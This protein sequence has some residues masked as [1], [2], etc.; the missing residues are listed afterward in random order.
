MAYEA[1]FYPGSSVIAEN[2]KK[3]MNPDYE[4]KTMRNIA[5][6][7][8]V[9]LLSHRTPG[10]GYKTV[11][12]PLDEMDFEEDAVKD[13]VEPL[14]GAKK[15]IRIRYV[16]FADSMYNAPAHPYDRARTY[17][18]RYRGVDTGTLSGRQV[19]EMR[20]SDLEEMSKTLIESE[21]FDTAKT[22]LR[23]ATVHGHSLRLDENGLMFDALQRYVFDE[24]SGH[25]KYVK[26]QIGRPLDEVID[27][28]EPIAEEELKNMTTIYRFDNISLKDDEEVIEVVSEI[29]AAR[30]DGGYGLEVFNDDLKSKL[31]DN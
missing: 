5:D 15:G 25:V 16:Q 14:D 7:D 3:H 13:F 10:E 21:L 29:H 19:V 23:G 18:R 17:M 20:E 22:G 6:D 11:H 27:V 26:D 1:Q 31:G 28:G 4:L 8:I 30:T 24:E 9:K 12:P 2:R